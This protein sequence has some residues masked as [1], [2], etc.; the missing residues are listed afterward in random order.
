[1]L[2]QTAHTQWLRSETITFRLSSNRK[3]VLLLSMLLRVKATSFPSFPCKESIVSC[4]C[5]SGHHPKAVP[6]FANAALLLNEGHGRGK[7]F[8]LC[9][10]KDL[11]EVRE[12]DESQQLIATYFAMQLAWGKNPWCRQEALCYTMNTFPSASISLIWCRAH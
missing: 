11:Q 1:M 9:N 10:S 5:G 12:R 8:S 2:S 3:P 4:N 7:Y 6:V